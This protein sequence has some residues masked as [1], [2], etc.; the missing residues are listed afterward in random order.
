MNF[1][2]ERACKIVDGNIPSA[3]SRYAASD[4]PLGLS[5]A[6]SNGVL[7]LKR[8]PAHARLHATRQPVSKRQNSGGVPFP[9]TRI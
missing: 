3:S 1:E 5:G 4:S 8:Q 7:A 9:L 6:C 2:L